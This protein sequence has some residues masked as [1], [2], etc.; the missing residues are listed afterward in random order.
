MLP[1]SIAA[2]AAGFPGYSIIPTPISATDRQLQQAAAAYYADAYSPAAAASVNG[3]S[4]LN[5]HV[6][7]T[8]STVQRSEPSPMP[9]TSS[10]MH[11]DQFSQQRTAGTGT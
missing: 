2:S 10:P 7:T 8:M 5:G 1:W 6:A 9:I 4:G 3:L 11:R